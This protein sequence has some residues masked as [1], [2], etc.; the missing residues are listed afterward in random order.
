MLVPEWLVKGGITKVKLRPEQD[1]VFC[2]YPEEQ[3]AFLVIGQSRK[4][5]SKRSFQHV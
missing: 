2:F 4:A 5:I 1:E 3:K